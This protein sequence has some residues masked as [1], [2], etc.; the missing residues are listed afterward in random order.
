MVPCVNWA[1]KH[2]LRSAFRPQRF[3]ELSAEVVYESRIY[4]SHPFRNERGKDGA[5]S[6]FQGFTYPDIAWARQRS[7]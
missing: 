1:V 6:F 5:A 4:V 3:R 2:F 7:K